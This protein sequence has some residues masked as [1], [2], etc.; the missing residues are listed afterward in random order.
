MDD[1][2]HY[3]TDL[4]AHWWRTIELLTLLGQSGIV[5][6]PDKFQFAMREIDFAGFRVTED[7]VEVLP[8]YYSAI[9]DFPT[10][11]STTDI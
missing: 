6:N 8:K 3:D 4:E 11:T 2:V 10:P 7:R 5:L 9:A 1:T